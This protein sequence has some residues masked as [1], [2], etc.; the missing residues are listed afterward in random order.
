MKVLLIYEKAISVKC[1]KNPCECISQILL[2]N[3]VY[4]NLEWQ[5]FH[6]MENTEKSRKLSAKRKIMENSV[7]ESQKQN[8]SK[9]IAV[10]KIF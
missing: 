1:G 4:I 8:I 6:N 10:F 3:S 7:Y 5:V 2:V 9:K